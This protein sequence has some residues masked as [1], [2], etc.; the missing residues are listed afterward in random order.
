MTRDKYWTSAGYYSDESWEMLLLDKPIKVGQ[1][2]PYWYFLHNDEY[3]NEKLMKAG[4][5]IENLIYNF[6]KKILGV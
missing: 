4:D 3:I 1:K 2:H 6:V 5:F